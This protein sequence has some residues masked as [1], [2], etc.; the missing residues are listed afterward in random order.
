MAS[1]SDLLYNTSDEAINGS[2]DIFGTEI[3]S[4]ITSED[5]FDLQFAVMYVDLKGEVYNR[6]FG[7]IKKVAW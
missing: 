6:L 5:S 3:I 2:G 1:L 4:N 7:R